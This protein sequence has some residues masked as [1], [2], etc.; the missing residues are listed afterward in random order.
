M[1]PMQGVMHEVPM[2]VCS[3][4]HHLVALPVDTIVE[5]DAVVLNAPLSHGIV[6]AE[7]HGVMQ[8]DLVMN[9][10]SSGAT[11]HDE[12]NVEG[13]DEVNSGR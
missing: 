10:A 5:K 13:K 3:L 1:Y 11:A 12:P 8:R 6:L 7:A 4:F 9:L 2:F